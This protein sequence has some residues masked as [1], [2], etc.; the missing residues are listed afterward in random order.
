MHKNII[1]T[2]FLITVSSPVWAQPSQG[3]SATS[4]LSFDELARLALTRN[5]ALQAARESL[6]QTQ[7][8]LVQAQVWPNPS[9]DLSKKSDALF[10][11][12]GDTGYAVTL[13]QP[14]ELGGKR[15][16]RAR[17]AELSIAVAQ[18]DMAD[19]ERQLIGRLRLLYEETAGAAA[20]I[21]LFERLEQVNNQMISTMN[22]RLRA[23][24]ASQLDSRL[25]QAQTNQVRA[26]QLM[27]QNQLTAA[28]LQIRTLAGLSLDEP[29]LMRRPLV[30]ADAPE[31]EDV[32]LTRALQNRP[33][34]K[35]A[36]LREELAQAGIT[37]AKSQAVPDATAF[38]RYGQDSIPVLATGS[39]RRLFEREKSVEVGVSIP[40]PLFNRE[41]GNIAEATSRRLQV[42][43]ERE[44]L[45][46]T[47]RQEV[48]SAFRRYDTAHKTVEI[49]QTGVLQ[50][51]QE[52]FRIVQLA[53]NLGDLRLL[54]I[55]NQQRV[56]IDAETTSVNA[57]TELGSARAEL[58]RVVGD[59]VP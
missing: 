3:I 35:A 31:T 47:V 23:G 7:A 4:G 15:S 2:L 16:K 52:S 28:V 32:V 8:R 44:N 58:A 42:R 36:R 26:E 41:Q 5:K 34:L 20:R 57:Q 9:I 48:V 18:A 40:L 56:L 39:T 29:L 11:N 17:V 33:D 19:S 1:F 50:Q 53:Y 38:L 46:A 13:A 27:A 45:E 6:R 10:A 43:A 59:A 12:D 51:N 25:L 14:V 21:D 30:L 54:D 22:V 24:D 55:V 49:L 37:L